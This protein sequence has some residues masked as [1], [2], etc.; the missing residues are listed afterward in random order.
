MPSLFE[1]QK[2][3]ALECITPIFHFFLRSTVN[4]PWLEFSVPHVTHRQRQM[5]KY[6]YKQLDRETDTDI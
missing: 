1:Q 4:P 3:T 5:K 2:V 6:A